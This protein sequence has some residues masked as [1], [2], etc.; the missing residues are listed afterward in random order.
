VV[1][2]VAELWHYLETVCRKAEL[3][4]GSLGPPPRSGS[5]GAVIGV[6]RFG[7]SAP[8]QNVRTTWASPRD[9]VVATALRILGKHKEA[10][11]RAP[12]VTA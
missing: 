5:V 12:L 2:E 3:D 8:G 9:H 7:A 10:E 6:D 1:A 4:A 11:Q